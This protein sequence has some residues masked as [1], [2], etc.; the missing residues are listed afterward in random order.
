MNR[1]FLLFFFVSP[2]LTALVLPAKVQAS[3]SLVKDTIT[4][5]RPS[6]STPLQ[7]ALSATDTQATVF[8]NLSRFIAS[9][10]ARLMQGTPQDMI[11]ASMSAAN[12]PASGQRIVYFTGAIAEAHTAGSVIRTPVT[13][14]HTISFSTTALPASGKVQI[15]F[16]VGDTADQSSPS[17]TGFSFN[18]L[19]QG[20]GIATNIYAQGIT[21]NAA[22]GCQPT[23]ST[24]TI[25]C[26][27]S[28]AFAGGAVTITV[29]YLTP[30]LVNPT[31]TAAAGTADTWAVIIKTLDNNSVL[32]DS[33]RVKIG[34]IDSVEVYATVDPTFSFTIA[35]KTT[36]AAVNVGN[37]TGCTTTETINT[38]ISSSP[39]D[40]N[41]G[42]LTAAG[43]NVSSQ[44]LTITTNGA[45]GYVLT[46]TSGGHL[47]NPE[48]GYWINDAQQTPTAN[49]TPA[50]VEIS[51]GTTAFGIRPCG[52]DVTA[53]TW[54]DGDQNCVTAGTPGTCQYANPS[55]TFYYTLAQDATGP[56]D[57]SVAAGNGL[58]TV[59]YAATISGVVPAGFYRTYLTYVATPTF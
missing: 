28:S 4:S 11:V 7:T 55:T 2:F 30:A 22:T 39:T 13:A 42:T 25:E 36:G 5:S 44:L 12:T 49:D 50:P 59:E 3:L 57:N 17:A 37:T 18:G 31:K 1:K 40:V 33:V 51:T 15:T 56:I 16:P 35:G 27:L 6:A 23:A 46:A 48:T 53:A 21:V 14:K 32:L 8:D 20:G 29:G 43:V 45:G 24:G 54:S 47:L 38:G 10:S 9:D 26:T 52:L 41:L 58:V 34:T 19:S